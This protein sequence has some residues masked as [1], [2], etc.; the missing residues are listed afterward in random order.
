M[1]PTMR[2]GVRDPV[3]DEYFV[4]NILLQGDP[5][6]NARRFLVTDTEDPVAYP[7]IHLEHWSRDRDNSEY[8]ETCLIKISHEVFSSLLENDSISP[9][10]DSYHYE[11]HPS[12]RL[13]VINENGKTRWARLFREWSRR[14]RHLLIPGVHTRGKKD[15][16]LLGGA[17]NY[18]LDPDGYRVYCFMAE[19]S[20]SHGDQ[21]QVSV[22]EIRV[23]RFANK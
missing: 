16:R 10:T 1:G 9:A 15:F 7:V 20:T 3:N 14:I 12:D 22:R 23:V 18:D 17:L 19:F 21:V 8:E 5:N 13:Y 2:D 4:L 6:Y 11:P